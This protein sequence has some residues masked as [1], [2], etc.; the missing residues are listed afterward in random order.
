MDID[1]SVLKKYNVDLIEILGIH[2][3]YF[4][5]GGNG[6]FTSFTHIVNNLTQ[7][8]VSSVDSLENL[9]LNGL[10]RKNIEND[11]KSNKLA[12]VR[13]LALI[14]GVEDFK[15]LHFKRASIGNPEGNEDDLCGYIKR[16]Y[17]K[18]FN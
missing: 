5:S 9:S 7:I 12:L 13:Y 17:K 6:Y 2:N 3:S 16:E 4:E 14:N 1:Y 10:R 11:L 8:L 15:K 18:Y